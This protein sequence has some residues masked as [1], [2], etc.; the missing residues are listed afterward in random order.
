MPNLAGRRYEKR[1]F[2][3]RMKRANGPVINPRLLELNIGADNLDD[4]E[5]I[6]YFFDGRREHKKRS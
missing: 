2:F 5:T 1:R 4:I 6:F 3:L